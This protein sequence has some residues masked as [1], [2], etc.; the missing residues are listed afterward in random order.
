MQQFLYPTILIVGL[1]ANVISLADDAKYNN[2]SFNDQFQIKLNEVLYKINTRFALP[3][4]FGSKIRPE[5]ICGFKNNLEDVEEFKG[6]L[7]VTKNYVEE[8]ES[9]TVQLQWL[10]RKE[11]QTKLPNY[12][13]GNIAD[14]RWCTG[15]LISEKHVLTAG[16]CFDIQKKG[17]KDVTP[18]QGSKYAEPEVLATLQKVNF[19]YQ[20]NNDTGK[21]RKEISFPVIKL[22]EY[23]EG[24]D[25]L[26]YAIV[27][28]GSDSLGNFAEKDFRPA[29]F[30]HSLIHD[31]SI[32]VIF[33]HPDGQFKKIGT[34]HLIASVGKY[35]F[36]DNID[37]L[38]G[39]SGSGV[40]DLTGS[41]VGIHTNGGCDKNSGKGDINIANKGVSS[42]AIAKVS[43]LLQK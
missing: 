33:Q 17:N 11:I 41:I 29:K 42:S 26:D 28:I 22:L 19:K 43:K 34:G 24:E 10:T 25:K 20:L 40:R 27:E 3:Y 16:H 18:F 7:N 13:L 38:S 5:T 39:S 32:L 1:M 4:T 36:Y 9:S 30:K 21:K 35:I 31:N 23:R 37:T 6:N 8:H 14:K 12:S 15:T 2:V